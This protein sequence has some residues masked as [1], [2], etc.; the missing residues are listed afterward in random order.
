MQDEGKDLSASLAFDMADFEKRLE[1]TQ[2][3]TSRVLRQSVIPKKTQEVELTA[4]VSSPAA[5][6]AA[7]PKESSKQ[8]AE[9]GLLARLAREAKE[10]LDSMHSR[11]Q[12][13]Q[14]KARRLHEALDRILKFLIP[15]IQH[16]N[17]IEHKINSTYRLDARTVFA[18]LRWQEATVD[19]RKLGLAEE[20][21]IAYVV[22]NV[23]LTSPEPVLIKRPW[24]QFDAL[25]KELHHLRLNVLDDLEE[26]YKKPKQEWLEARL[27]PTLQVQIL[28]KGN[29]ENSRIDVLT[30][31]IEDL[32]PAAFRLEPEDITVELLDDLGLYLIGRSDKPPRIL[33]CS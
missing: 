19:F 15:F 16:A 31:N 28:F 18:D 6:R 11:D 12:G 21:H 13:K 25:K 10:N 7:S 20:T 2:Q 14:A 4:I 33:R 9:S 30:R 3:E 29:Y 32:G 8:P 26:L 24:D 22:L 23:N 27:D 1:E 17:N 5:T